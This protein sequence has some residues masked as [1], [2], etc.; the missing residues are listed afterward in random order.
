MIRWVFASASQAKSLDEIFVATEDERIVREV[1]SWGGNAIL[2]SSD[3][4]TGTDRILEVIQKLGSKIHL[5]KD[6]IINIQGDEPGI[7]ADL[8]DGVVHLKRQRPEWVV[9]TAAT[10]MSLEEAKDPS[11]VKVVFNQNFQALYFSRSQIPYPGNQHSIPEPSRAYFRHLGIYCF[12]ADFLIQYRDLPPSSWEA[13]E[14]LEQLRILQAGY[15]I[16]IHIIERASLSVDY[17]EDIAKVETD[18]RSR[19]LM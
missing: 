14:S 3:H 12:N 9:T 1:E 2:T 7:E 10:P 4:P 15:S 11:R 19:G 18:F 16:G 6:I 8:I 5:E 17:P 13:M